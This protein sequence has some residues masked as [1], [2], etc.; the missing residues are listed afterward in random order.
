MKRERKHEETVER[1]KWSERGRVIERDLVQE[2]ERGNY[3][4]ENTS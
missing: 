4:I 1:G 3:C 2:S